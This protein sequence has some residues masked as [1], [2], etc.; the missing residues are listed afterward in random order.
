MS[1][2]FGVALHRWVEGSERE[3]REDQAFV[4]LY[5]GSSG[6]YVA[7]EAEMEAATME[8]PGC[9]QTRGARGPEPARRD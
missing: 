4:R 2:S 1:F 8:P 6:F 3:R 7:V 9:G 5:S